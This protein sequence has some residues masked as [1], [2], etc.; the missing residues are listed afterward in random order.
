[1]AKLNFQHHYSSLQ[2]HDPSEIIVFCDFTITI[3]TL[4]MLKTIMLLN[5]FVKTKQ[6]NILLRIF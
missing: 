4:L 2:S 6:F 3:T 5:I 1:M